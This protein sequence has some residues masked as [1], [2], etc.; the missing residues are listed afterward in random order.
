MFWIV[1]CLAVAAMLVGARALQRQ[2]SAGLCSTGLSDRFSWGLY[3]QGFLTLGSLAGGALFLA[4]LAGLF[5]GQNV[6]AP[7][8]GA[9]ALG[10][11]AGGGVMIASDLGKPFRSVLLALGKN[12]GSTMTWDFYTFALCGALALAAVI[13]GL[14][15]AVPGVA[16]SVLAL[17]VSGAFLLMHVLLLLAR[18]KSPVNQPFLALEIFMRGL[19]GGA[20]LLTLVTLI[21][22]GAHADGG[23]AAVVRKLAFGSLSTLL[24]ALSLIVALAHLVSQ[25]AKQRPENAPAFRWINRQALADVA[26]AVA[27][28]IGVYAQVAFLVALAAIAVI[29][30]LI[31]EK[32]YLVRAFQTQPVLPAP[33][34]QW[35]PAAP[36]KPSSLELR[37]CLGG[38][39]LAFFVAMIVLRL[40]F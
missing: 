31:W 33:Y 11:L 35:E 38:V 17:V 15:G 10:C 9:V 27:L 8:A 37:V 29:L 24:L 5:L 36:Y 3:I 34:S 23:M 32:T 1:L 28:L 13:Y 14:C 4:G 7:V 26:I 30:V 18:Q 6:L 22:M 20:A 2:F 25:F 16:W 19:W 39:G 40:I 21:T 12:T